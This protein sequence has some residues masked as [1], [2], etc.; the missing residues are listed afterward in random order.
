M[1]K[2]VHHTPWLNLQDSVV[3]LFTLRNKTKH[4]E[5]TVFGLWWVN[6][7]Q[8]CNVFVHHVNEMKEHLALLY[9]QQYKENC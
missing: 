1:A 5:T 6:D 3:S 8:I 9:V 7:G 2:A 4:K